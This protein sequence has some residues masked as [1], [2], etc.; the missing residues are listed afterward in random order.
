MLWEKYTQASLYPLTTSFN[1]CTNPFS[2]S[3][4]SDVRRVSVKTEISQTIASG[5]FSITPT[6]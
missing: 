4:K 3:A 1:P 5:L 2:S 6:H